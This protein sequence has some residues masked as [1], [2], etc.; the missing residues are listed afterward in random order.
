METSSSCNG[1]PKVRLPQIKGRS[2]GQK[3]TFIVRVKDP[4]LKKRC[5]RS[6]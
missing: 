2:Q 5:S 6:R 3:A 1:D 4:G